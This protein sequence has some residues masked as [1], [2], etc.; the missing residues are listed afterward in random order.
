VR[1]CSAIFSSGETSGALRSAKPLQWATPVWR[2]LRARF[3][4]GE[5]EKQP[6]ESH[7]MS[8]PPRKPLNP[9]DL[10]THVSHKAHEG[11]VTERHPSE[12]NN[13]PPRS[14][15][16]PKRAQ[17]RAATERHPVENDRDPL[18]SPYAPRQARAQPAVTSDFAARDDAGP[19][20]PVRAPGGLP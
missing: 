19:L 5:R 9:I 1:R 16:A 11:A 14:P 8:I 10:S 13:A 20:P 3:C 2:E 17:L 18:R 12:D 4:Y 15:Y 6:Q 7:H